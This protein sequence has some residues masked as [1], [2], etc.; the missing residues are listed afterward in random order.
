MRT[1]V[2]LREHFAPNDGDPTYRVVAT[3]DARSSEHAVRQVVEA[4]D[5]DIPEA[6]VTHVAVP[7][8]NWRTGMH[9]L[10]AET[11]RRL[12]ST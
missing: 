3:V 4:M 6:G 7:T 2:V 8:R 11:R 12:I 1:Y 9:T 10:K 5:G